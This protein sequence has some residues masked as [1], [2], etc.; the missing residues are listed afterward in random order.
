V[1]EFVLQ[2]ISTSLKVTLVWTDAPGS[3][4][5]RTILKNDLDLSMMCASGCSSSSSLYPNGR[6]SADRTNNVEQI[7]IPASS[8]SASQ[9]YVITIAP[10]AIP[11][12][13]QPYALVI[14]G[15]FARAYRSDGGPEPSINGNDRSSPK[16]D[17]ISGAAVV[18]ILIAV[19]GVL[20]VAISVGYSKYRYGKWG[21]PPFQKK[22]F[23][24]TGHVVTKSIKSVKNVVT[25]STEMQNQK[26]SSAPTF[27]S[28]RSNA[29]IN[30]SSLLAP[31]DSSNSQKFV[32][33]TQSTAES[34]NFTK[35]AAA[36]LYWKS[37]EASTTTTTT[38]V[39]PQAKQPWRSVPPVSK[40]VVPSKPA[41]AL[42]PTPRP[43]LSLAIK[44]APMSVSKPVLKPVVPAAKPTIPMTTPS[45]SAMYVTSTAASI[46]SRSSQASQW[47]VHIDPQSGQRYW[48]HKQTK[49]T[50]WTDP[51]K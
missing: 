49:E 14:T 5:A 50:R 4:N 30:N 16:D 27:F 23:S 32:Q 38:P 51:T 7:E 33:Q 41:P 42:V 15:S 11:V 3:V 12:G 34:N 44:P 39:I 8:L 45:S 48:T 9:V 21:F 37:Q 25:P 26:K 1:F 10:F 24:A 47:A 31:L 22:I 6:T 35:P 20:F 36:K 43:A 17:P 46:P 29:K 18:V 13:P 2:Q 19:V 40:P 28:S